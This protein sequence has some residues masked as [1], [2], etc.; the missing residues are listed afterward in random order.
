[1]NSEEN[2]NVDRPSHVEINHRNKSLWKLGLYNK[3]KESDLLSIGLELTFLLFLG[4]F[5]IL[6]RQNGDDDREDLRI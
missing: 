6:V 5:Y 1:M 2:N 4:S 3:L